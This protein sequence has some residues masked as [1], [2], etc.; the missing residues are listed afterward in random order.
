VQNIAASFWYNA[1]KYSGPGPFFTT[2]YYTH[3]IS[4]LSNFWSP[5][6]R[7]CLEFLNSNTTPGSESYM[8]EF[9]WLL[10]A[11]IA[12]RKRSRIVT[13]SQRWNY[14]Q[15]TITSN[16]IKYIFWFTEGFD[17]W[18]R[19]RRFRYVTTPPTAWGLAERLRNC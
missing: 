12:I 11:D 1:N 18:C 6:M 15:T 3:E 2:T 8:L 4:Q 7:F 14:M 16:C 9:L 13:L 5:F 17:A 10:M 19:S